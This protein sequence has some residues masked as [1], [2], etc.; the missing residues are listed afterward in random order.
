MARSTARSG[1]A[2]APQ[3]RSSTGSESRPMPPQREQFERGEEH[4]DTLPEAHRIPLDQRAMTLT[5]ESRA[6]MREV[7]DELRESLVAA[8][9]RWCDRSAQGAVDPERNHRVVVVARPVLE[10]REVARRSAA[11]D[12]LAVRESAGQELVCN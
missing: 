7:V 1:R 11:L 3:Q 8:A 10:A 12:R 5:Q 6:R 2:S 4:R 9:D